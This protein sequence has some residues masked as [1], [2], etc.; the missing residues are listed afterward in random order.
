[1]AFNLVSHLILFNFFI[2]YESEDTESEDT[3]PDVRNNFLQGHILSPTRDA[4]IVS[5]LEWKFKDQ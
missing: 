3:Y 5:N 4:L 2:V 1:M